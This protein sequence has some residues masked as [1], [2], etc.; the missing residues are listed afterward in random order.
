MY[1]RMASD[2]SR[3]IRS[4]SW[5]LSCHKFLKALVVHQFNLKSATNRIGF[6]TAVKDA[7]IVA[8]RKLARK[9]KLKMVV[10]PLR[11]EI[12][13]PLDENL[14]PFAFGPLHFPLCIWPFAFGPL[15]LALCIWQVIDF[16]SSMIHFLAQISTPP[17][18]CR[19]RVLQLHWRPTSCR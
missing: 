11:P 2:R 8:F 9:R 18:S 10:G 7:A 14:S 17:G 15:H 1:P 6:I 12:A 16:S 13:L 3:E 5:N 19:P 4:A